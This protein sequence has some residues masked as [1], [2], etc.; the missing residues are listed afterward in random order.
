MERKE[1]N[2]ASSGSDN[3]RVARRQIGGITTVR[4]NRSTETEASDYNQRFTQRPIGGFR[5]IMTNNSATSASNHGVVRRQIGGITSVRTDNSNADDSNN[6]IVRRPIGGFRVVRNNDNGTSDYSSSSIQRPIGGFT[7]VRSNDSGNNGSVVRRQIGGFASVRTNN[8]G[9]SASN[10]RF[11]Q[12]PIGGFSSKR[13]SEGIGTLKPDDGRD[14]K[15][16]KISKSISD[17]KSSA[18]DYPKISSIYRNPRPHYHPTRFITWNCN[19]FSSRAKWDVDSLFELVAE[20]NSPEVICIQEARLKADGNERGRPLKDKDYEHIQ[21]ALDGPFCDYTPFWSLADKKYAGTLTLLKFTVLEDSG[22]SEN[23]NSEGSY[24]PDFVAFTPSSAI[25]LI[26][27]RLGMTRDECGLNEIAAISS[28]AKRKP[29]QTSLK[30]F[31]SPKAAKPAAKRKF[32]T[33]HEHNSEG[34]FQFFFFPGMDFVQT[35]V[36]NNGTKDESF[37]R[38]RDWDKTMLKFVRERKQILQALSQNKSSKSNNTSVDSS[39]YR[40]LLWCGDMNVAATYRDGSHWEA[41]QSSK[42][43]ND[44]S[45]VYE[46]FRDEAK[47]LGKFEKGVKRPENVG[48]PG[49]TPAERERFA[50]FLEEGNFCDVWRK[51]HP[52]GAPANSDNETSPWER[53]NYTWRGAL[54]K[55]F[56]GF[57]KYQGKGQRIDY[58]LLSPK[59]DVDEIKN[60]DI[61]GYGTNKQGMF[62]GSDHCA[63][64][65]RFYRCP[66]K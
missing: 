4:V 12:R 59:T 51:L 40:R 64:D 61:L 23:D 9:A 19:G 26:L 18:K 55:N 1:R 65:L 46:W 22:I 39:S 47:C 20:H 54:A 44:G 63:V 45:E 62:C 57:A 21:N 30:S 41:K 60:C 34:R 13:S 58:F 36:P 29:Q 56:G 49:F 5:T 3:G 33:R 2:E 31:F 7:T 66:R 17:D 10:H 25:D 27:R 24:D 38:R 8:S 48:I 53:P 32:C 16:Q 28:P 52:N 35:Y 6:N 14:G 43:R 37:A 11:I 15:R 42:T 50:T